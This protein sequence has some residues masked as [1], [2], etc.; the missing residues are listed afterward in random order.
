[1]SKIR[2]NELARQL[3]IPSHAI[4]EMLP[5]L[6]VTEKKTHSS[7]VDEPVAELI[8]KRLYGDEEPSHTSASASPVTDAWE[9]PAVHETPAPARVISEPIAAAPSAPPAVSAEHAPSADASRAVP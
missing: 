3:E 5:D 4:L 2:I 7:S 6:G 1:M 8:R 9:P